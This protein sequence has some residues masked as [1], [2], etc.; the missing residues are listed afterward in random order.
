MN[1]S[2]VYQRWREKTLQ[3]GR[4]EGRQ[5]EV[6]GL[7]EAKFGALDAELSG[8][9]VPMMQLSAS[10]RA[11]FILTLSREDLIARFRR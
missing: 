1:L 7:L 2:P 11:R 8:I 9:V 5:E 3:E 4:Q 10:D 6:E